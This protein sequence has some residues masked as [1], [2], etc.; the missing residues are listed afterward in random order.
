MHAFVELMST[1]ALK[2]VMILI[3]SMENDYTYYRRCI[4]QI[5]LQYAFSMLY[6][7]L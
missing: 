7:T 3:V 4:I 5:K 6:P 1:D 2:Y